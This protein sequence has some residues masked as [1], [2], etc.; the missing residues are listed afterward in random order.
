MVWKVPINHI[1]DCYFCIVP[2]I[3]NGMSMKKNINT[4]VSEYTISKWSVPHGDGLSVPEPP[5][6]FAIYPDG[7]EDVSSN[8][9]NNSHQIQEMQT[10]CKAQTPPIIRSQK[11]S[12]MTSSGIS[13][14][15]T[16]RQNH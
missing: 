7:D 12:S 1:T 2:P 14:F 6:Y 8:S 3:Q 15:Q 4:C 5:E 11:V 9:N 10:T 13:N 16:I